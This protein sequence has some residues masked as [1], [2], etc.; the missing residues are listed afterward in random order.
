ME[1]NE[2]GRSGMNSAESTMEKGKVV[3]FVL[4][5][6]KRIKQLEPTPDQRS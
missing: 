3:Q 6:K 5:K 2:K 4:P 1:D